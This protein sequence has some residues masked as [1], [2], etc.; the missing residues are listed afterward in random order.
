MSLIIGVEQF[1]DTI[2]VVVRKIKTVEPTVLSKKVVDALAT[3]V[4]NEIKREVDQGLIKRA[5]LS[6]DI[7]TPIEIL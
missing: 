5:R 6:L 1:G 4:R 3:A 7:E 2:H